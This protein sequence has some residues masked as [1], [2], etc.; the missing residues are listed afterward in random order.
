MKATLRFVLGSLGVICTSFMAGNAT[1]LDVA[2]CSEPAGYSNFH[3]SGLVKKGDSGFTK[4]KIP[5]GTNTLKR[6]ED[7]TFDILYS[8]VLNINRSVRNDG[9]IVEKLRHGVMDATFLVYYSNNTI[10]LYTFYKDT[11]GFSRF[12]LLQSKGGEALMHSSSVFS[13]IC[14]ELYLSLMQ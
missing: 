6:Q 13:G 2:I 8:D 1:A 9:A 3:Y 11:E 12:D 5:G 10:E 7:G 14:S 4:N